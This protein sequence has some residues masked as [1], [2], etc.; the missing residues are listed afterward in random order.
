MALHDTVN[1]LTEG[2]SVHCVVEVLEN[3]GVV[4]VNVIVVGLILPLRCVVVRRRHLVVAGGGGN[5]RER[6]GGR[7]RKEL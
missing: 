6:S 1:N 4:T 3:N 7:R 2:V 5:E